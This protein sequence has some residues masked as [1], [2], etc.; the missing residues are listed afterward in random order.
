MQPA[1]G[2]RSFTALLSAARHS[3]WVI[4]REIAQP[5]TLRENRSKIA[6]KY[7][8]PVRMR[9]Y[10]MSATHTWFGSST[11]KPGSRFGAYA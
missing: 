10:V 9:M 5:T 1:A 6:A 8:K 7:T 4:R 11:V 2:R 3:L